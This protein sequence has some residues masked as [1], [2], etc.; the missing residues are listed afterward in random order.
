MGGQWFGQ[1]SVKPG[2]R[3]RKRNAGSAFAF[4]G[5]LSAP[6]DIGG[7]CG[8]PVISPCIMGDGAMTAAPPLKISIG[9]SRRGSPRIVFSAG[10]R[11]GRIERGCPE[12]STVGAGFGASWVNANDEPANTK[13]SA[14]S[15]KVFITVQLLRQQV[16]RDRGT[17]RRFRATSRGADRRTI[18]TAADYKEGTRDVPVVDAGSDSVSRSHTAPCLSKTARRCHL[19][20]GMPRK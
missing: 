7:T 20:I 11:G 18:C 6:S 19:A 15:P 17:W 13:M 12:G 14:A 4:R 5:Y 9:L 10:V 2:S 8:C 3:T 1:V 16:K